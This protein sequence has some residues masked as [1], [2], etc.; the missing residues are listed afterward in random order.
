MILGSYHQAGSPS[1]PFVGIFEPRESKEI[2]RMTTYSFSYTPGVQANFESVSAKRTLAWSS[3]IKKVDGAQ[4]GFLDPNQT[5]LK[6]WGSATFL[7]TG[8]GQV[9]AK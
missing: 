3:A 8:G 1:G 6:A 4:E 9:V 2:D 5:F 7:C